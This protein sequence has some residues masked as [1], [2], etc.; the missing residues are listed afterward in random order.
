MSLEFLHVASSMYH[1]LSKHSIIVIFGLKSTYGFI[2]IFASLEMKRNSRRKSKISKR[3]LKF[4]R[5]F[6]YV[7]TIGDFNASQLIAR[8]Q[9]YTW[10]LGPNNFFFKVSILNCF[11][12]L[13]HELN[14]F[15]LIF[16][17]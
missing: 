1:A 17:N 2:N 5:F 10:K 11:Y 3:R 12:I 13:K 16:L 6:N 15:L 7:R 14:F 4:D 8:E 9:F